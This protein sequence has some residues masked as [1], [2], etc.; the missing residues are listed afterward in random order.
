M[1]RM[2]G[3]A[4]LLATL[5]TVGLSSLPAFAQTEDGPKDKRSYIGIGGNIGLNGEE[6]ALGEGG[7]SIVS[8]T[9]IIEY[10]S[11]RNSTVFGDDTASMFALT[12]EIPLTNASGDITAIPFLGAGIWLHGEVDPLISAGVDVPLGQDFTLTNRVNFGFDDD[13]TDIGVTIGVGYNFELF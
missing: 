3:I 9:R 13:D 1:V 6:S 12:G 2:S 5:A 11:L 4:L 10:L 8:R 7:F